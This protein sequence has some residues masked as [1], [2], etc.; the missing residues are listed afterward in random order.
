MLVNGDAFAMVILATG[1]SAAPSGSSLYRSVQELLG[2][3]PGAS[4]LEQ[5]PLLKEAMRA[6]AENFGAPTVGLP[7]AE[8]AEDKLGVVIRV[9]IVWR[10]AQ[11]ALEPLG[12]I[13]RPLVGAKDPES[14]PKD[15]EPA[16]ELF[17]ECWISIGAVSPLGFSKKRRR[18]SGNAIMVLVFAVARDIREFFH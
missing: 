14:D 9:G 8:K 17:E 3:R 4:R 16:R 12:S 7:L 10:Q 5:L 13:S 6:V 15:C 2:A 18:R 11:L 1:V